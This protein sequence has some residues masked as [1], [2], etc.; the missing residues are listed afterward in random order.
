MQIGGKTHYVLFSETL[1][2]LGV[3]PTSSKQLLKT[4]GTKIQA[5]PLL[6][7][8]AHSPPS[9]HLLRE[10][11][12]ASARGCGRLPAQSPLPFPLSRLAFL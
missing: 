2:I 11:G 6:C 4:T 8:P 12:L 7:A 1:Q 10:G 9:Q 5:L 3:E